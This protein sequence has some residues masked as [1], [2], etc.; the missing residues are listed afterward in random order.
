MATRK[1]L[2]TYV[3]RIEF[4]LGSTILEYDS[5]SVAMKTWA[6]DFWSEKDHSGLIVLNFKKSFVKTEKLE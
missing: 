3:V 6:E 5:F 4:L 2:V 1:F